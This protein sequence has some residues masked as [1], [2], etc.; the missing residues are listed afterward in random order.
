M[1]LKK[2]AQVSR[3]PKKFYVIKGEIIKEAWKK[4]KNQKISISE[5]FDIC[6]NVVTPF[7]NDLDKSILDFSTGISLLFLIH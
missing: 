4:Y 2:G 7:M 5:L 6:S 3:S 1:A